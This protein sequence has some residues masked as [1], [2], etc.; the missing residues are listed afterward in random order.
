MRGIRSSRIFG[1]YMELLLSVD[2]YLAVEEQFATTVSLGRDGSGYKGGNLAQRSKKVPLP[3]HDETGQN[4]RMPAQD[5]N[6]PVTYFAQT[7]F[8]NQRKRFGIK[9]RDRRSHMYVIG[10]TGV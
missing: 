2:V 4:D 9:R 1:L 3:E 6:N 10:K 5:P 7:N 8:R